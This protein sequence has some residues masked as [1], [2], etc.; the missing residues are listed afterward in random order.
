MRPLALRLLLAVS[1][2]ASAV[3][4]TPGAAS[5]APPGVAGAPPG[6]AAVTTAATAAGSG[7]WFPVDP[8]TA[9]GG[10]GTVLAAGADRDVTLRTGRDVPGDAQALVLQ[11]RTSDAAGPG[12]LTIGPPDGAG[13]AVVAFDTGAAS[14]TTIVRAHPGDLTR[15][16]AT[17]GVRLSLVVVAYLSAAGAT[18]AAGPV[19]TV[20]PAVVVDSATGAGGD[21]PGRA[22]TSVVPLAGTAGLPASGASAVWVS[23]QTHGTGAG[24]VRLSPAG[25]AAAGSAPVAARWTTTLALA[26][27]SPEGDLAYAWDGAGLDGLR[28]TVLGW[29]PDGGAGAAGSPGP[30]TS[31]PA[32][33][34]AVAPSVLGLSRLDLTR[35]A[36]P[37]AASD[38]VVSATVVTSAVGGEIR[39]S[40]SSL[41]LLLAPQV[42]A[43]LAARTT[44]TV[45]LVVPVSRAG[46]T[47]V[48]VPFGARVTGL[49]VLGYRSG[50]VRPAQD[51]EAPTVAVTSPA[52][53]ARIDQATRPVVTL[54]GT[55]R[56][57]GSGVRAVTVTAD[58]ADLGPARLRATASGAV[59]WSLETAVPAGD[60]RLE[61]TATDWA[62]RTRTVGTAFT[63]TA[64]PAEELVVAP[65]VAVLD[66]ET[67]TE[68]AADRLV[69]SGTPDVHAGDAVVAGSS[70]TTPDGLMRLVT[71]VE[72]TGPSTVVHTGAAAF[73]DVFL[74]ADITADDVGLDGT[75][76]EVDPVT[77]RVLAAPAARSVSVGHTFSLRESATRSPLTTSLAADLTVHLSFDLKITTDWDWLDTTTRLD[78]F[79]LLFGLDTTVDV[80][81]SLGGAAE[82]SVEFPDRDI[83]LGR[84]VLALGP[85]PVVLTPALE[86]HAYVSAEVEGKVGLT[87]RYTSGFT[88]GVRCEDGS[89]SP[90]SEHE[91]SADPSL[92]ATVSGTVKAGVKLPLSVKL[93]EVAGPYVMADLGPRL[94]LTAHLVEQRLDAALEAQLALKV[95]AK[96]EVLDHDL[97]DH[98]WDL[99]LLKTTLWEDSWP[100]FPDDD[101]TDP[102]GDGPGGEDP[103]DPGGDGPGGGGPGGGGT[104]PGQQEP[105]WVGDGQGSGFG[106]TD[107]ALDACLPT[108]VDHSERHAVTRTGLDDHGRQ[109]Y[110]VA[111]E[112]GAAVL[113][114][115]GYT[116]VS[117][118]LRLPDVPDDFGVAVEWTRP[119]DSIWGPL[120]YS[121]EAYPAPDLGPGMWKASLTGMQEALL[122][123]GWDEFTVFAPTE[124][125]GVTSVTETREWLDIDQPYCSGDGGATIAD[126]HPEDS[127][128]HWDAE[129]DSNDIHFSVE[130]DLLPAETSRVELA[131]YSGRVATGEPS[132]ETP[133]WRVDGYDRWTE[134]FD[135]GHRDAA[136]WVGTLSLGG[137]GRQQCVARA[138][139][140]G[141]GAG[142]TPLAE[143]RLV[144]GSFEAPW[145]IVPS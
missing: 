54:A 22:A 144:G 80:E 47:Y 17:T 2:V 31:V 100:W 23:V 71:S 30:L 120:V 132:R 60:H 126:G 131:C 134:R 97:L 21:L 141:D 102:G 1:L 44:S 98:S 7:G 76:L 59:A 133:L 66:A 109:L 19:T 145:H 115:D 68:V 24:S 114:G 113:G 70:E 6:P 11:V 45:T 117:L 138:Y 38:V 29:V 18:P 62:G 46:D 139:A 124:S 20:E 121:T 32:T 26:A 53:G 15:L 82:R 51:T 64:A 13:D 96:V 34:V 40:D 74:Q 57:T 63:V 50:E 93:Y 89:C 49:T 77:G 39:A 27:L 86:P 135:W 42:R 103:D 10:A 94:S 125:V 101:G 91:S 61:A 75:T 16:R 85:V 92:V 143:L 108:Y 33:A 137:A 111:P 72:R 52:A 79:E 4:V 56:D 43:P 78:R 5:A 116:W 35:G 58:G 73:T 28:I 81:A 122:R 12:T 99:G 128:L 112:V 3:V 136:A 9:W 8:A 119:A 37:A 36:V 142:A 48:S 104:D 129:H 127:G 130:A 83:V 140:D 84:V 87:Y 41:F 107:V 55:A 105:P 65:D 123:E 67:V 25:D 14:A 88:A 106:L 118:E 95:G 69:L 90:V 110:R